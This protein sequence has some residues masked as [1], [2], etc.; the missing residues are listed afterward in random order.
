MNHSISIQ[1]WDLLNKIFLSRCR[2]DLIYA[3]INFNNF[4]LNFIRMTDLNEKIVQIRKLITDQFYSVEND[5]KKICIVF[6]MKFTGKTTWNKRESSLNC[7][8]HQCLT[9]N[10]ISRETGSQTGRDSVNR[11]D[12]VTKQLF[13]EN[14]PETKGKI[15]TLSFPDDQQRK[16]LRPNDNRGITEE[17]R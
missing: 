13:V 9:S 8:E 10:E 4:F 12:E 5:S 17:K 11:R 6:S 7:N 3:S 1:L 15:L 16:G 14:H 2:I